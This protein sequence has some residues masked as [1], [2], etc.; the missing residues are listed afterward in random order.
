MSEI[1]LNGLPLSDFGAAMLKGGYAELMRPAEMKDWIYNDIPSMNGIQYIAPSSP[2]VKERE[3]SLTFVIKGDTDAD[4]M[5]NYARFVEE[6]MRGTCVLVVPALSQT[7][8]LKYD[9]CTS[10]DNIDL[11]CCKL[12]VKF[13][14]PN[15]RNFA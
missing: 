15:P 4:F 1:T 10:F 11:K 8:S 3:V 14:E 5:M 7:F 13:T 6:L 9:A 2:K 12:A